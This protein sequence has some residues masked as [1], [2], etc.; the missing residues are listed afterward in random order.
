MTLTNR[1]LAFFLSALALVLFGFSLA[2]FLAAGCYLNRQLDDRL[3]ATLN[4]LI[5]A[6]E[7]EPGGLEWDRNDRLVQSGSSLSQSSILWTIHDDQGHLLDQSAEL[8]LDDPLR[9]DLGP[10][11]GSETIPRHR[12]PTGESRRCLRRQLLATHVDVTQ[13]PE[14]KKKT[15]SLTFTVCASTEPLHALQRSLG[16]TLFGISVAVLVAALI[17]G[18]WFCRRALAPITRM[19][20]QAGRMHADD[21]A[22]RLK[23]PHSGDE[24]E[25][26]GQSFN[27]V[28]DRLHEALDRQRRFTGDASHELRTPLTALLGQVEVALRHSRSNT[29]YQQTLQAVQQQS[30]H[31]A[32]IVEMLL[33]LARSTSEAQLQELES[34]DLSDWLPDYLKSW[35][36]HPRSADIQSKLPG[37]HS[38]RVQVQSPL[39]RQLLDNLLD[40]ALK[41]SEPSTPITVRLSGDSESVSVAVEDRGVGIEPKDLPRVFEPFF[42]SAKARELGRP[43]VGLG[44][45][46]AMRIAQLFRG[47][48]DVFSESGRGSRFVLTLP[49]DSKKKHFVKVPGPDGSSIGS[50]FGERS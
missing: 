18:R 15:P 8:S 13:S 2:L 11:E 48:L 29:E 10:T 33:Y 7:D 24:V 32:R 40:N 3:E 46:V 49:T 5:A 47:K 19:V 45:S 26:L 17:G 41:Y 39:F 6:A 22:V 35:S 38:C 14:E 34:I 27:G 36:Q 12:T 4:T 30:R 28:L 20:D 44:L 31:L 43:G 16:L 50:D 21:G 42:R 25:A 23:V 37:R 1:L 9:R